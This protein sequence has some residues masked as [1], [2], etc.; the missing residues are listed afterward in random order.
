[1]WQRFNA[2]NALALASLSCTS[3]RVCLGDTARAMSEENVEVVRRAYGVFDTD[4]GR[5]LRMLD[6]SITWVSPRHALEPGSR[7]GH[8]GV[9]D[10][11]A[12]TGMAWDQTTHT[13]E[14]LIEAAD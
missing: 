9:R 2:M 11:F 14:E 12:A 4:V 7:H 5:L 6:P 13:L 8:Q 3:A 10:A 1:M